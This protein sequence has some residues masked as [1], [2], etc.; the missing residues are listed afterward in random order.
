MPWTTTDP[1]RNANAS[2]RG[3]VASSATGRQTTVVARPSTAITVRR[4]SIDLTIAFH[5]AC[6]AA[7]TTTSATTI[8]THLRARETSALGV[9]IP[10]GVTVRCAGWLAPLGPG[11]FA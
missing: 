1:I 5:D 3:G 8:T 11:P 6:R 10:S 2:L 7:A 9:F 4:S